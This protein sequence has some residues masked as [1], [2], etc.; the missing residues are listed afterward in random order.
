MHAAYV[1]AKLEANPKKGVTDSRDS[2]FWGAKLSGDSGLLRPN[3]SRVWPVALITA[4]VASLGLVSRSLLESLIGSWTAIFLIRRRTLSLIDI[5]FEALRATAPGDVIRLSGGLVD[6]LWSWVLI[7]PLCIAN[8]R[9]QVC[10]T[11]CTTDASDDRIACATCCAH[12]A[13]RSRD[14]PRGLPHLS[15]VAFHKVSR[16]NRQAYWVLALLRTFR[17]YGKGHFWLENPDGSF[18]WPLP[19]FEE[20]ATSKVDSQH[21]FRLDQ[22]FCFCTRWRKR[23][24]FAVGPSSAL[25]GA[26]V[27][28][29][30]SRQ[31]R[32]PWTS[33]AQSYP[34][35]LAELIASALALAVSCGWFSSGHRVSQVPLSACLA[36]A[37][38]AR[39]G[40]A[41]L[42]GPRV[43]RKP[44]DPL[45]GLEDRPLQ[46]SAALLQGQ[47][48]WEAFLSWV[49][50][51]LAV[52]L[53][54]TGCT[55][56]EVRCTSSAIR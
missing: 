1:R 52:A 49:Q 47:R 4:R 15:P 5:A 9:A 18:M 3:P 27:L 56:L 37:S 20:F 33:L 8:L 29:G 7:A 39:L 28:R 6:E 34:R 45:H 23:R 12:P 26:L 36:G 50:P 14:C 46:S 42:P 25:S 10:D 44:R 13:W 43:L 35:P 2:S 17:E 22:L 40:E 30:R 54:A 53:T 11:F 21:V 48:G 16:G 41:D 32:R 24:R 51:C 31:D 19:G 38:S 55:S